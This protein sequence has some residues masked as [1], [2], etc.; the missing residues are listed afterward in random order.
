MALDFQITLQTEFIALRPM[1]ATDFSLLSPIAEY[2]MWKYFTQDLADGNELKS[3]IDDALAAR[4]KNSRIPFTIIERSTG[5]VLGSTS[6][7][8]ISLRD[9]RMEIGW[10]WIGKDFQGTGV[11]EQIKYLLLKYSFETLHF[12]RIEAK[13]DVLN[14]PARKAMK[15]IGMIEEGI[16]RSHTLMT[17]GR[18]RDTIYYSVLLSEWNELK[19]LNNW[20]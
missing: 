8:N 14:T 19:K 10:T 3:W 12:E 6:F 17:A 9:R 2:P 1:Q 7:G 16:L 5:R 13:T 11:N 4:E 15:R 20:P 18:R